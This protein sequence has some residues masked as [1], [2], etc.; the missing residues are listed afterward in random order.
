[1]PLSFGCISKLRRL[2]VA[3]YACT[4]AFN[5]SRSGRSIPSLELHQHATLCCAKVLPGRKSGCRAGCRPDSSRGSLKIGP[6]ASLRPAGGQILRFFRIESGRNPARKP[7][8]R[9]GSSTVRSSNQPQ[10]DSKRIKQGVGRCPPSFW[11]CFVT[12]H[13]CSVLMSGCVARCGSKLK[14]AVQ[15]RTRLRSD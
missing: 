14:I 6:S 5:T 12:G 2:L 13:H 4:F 9:P 3:L 15:R 8:F 11:I 7:D 10:C 1:M